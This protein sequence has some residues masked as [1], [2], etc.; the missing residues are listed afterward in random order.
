[1]R[2]EQF[3]RCG[4]HLLVGRAGLDVALSGLGLLQQDQECRRHREVHPALLP[5]ER[6]DH[7]PCRWRDG[8][9]YPRLNGL[10]RHLDQSRFNR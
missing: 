6:L 10:R 7:G 3:Q 2:H 1:L 4:E 8:P 5:R 9:L